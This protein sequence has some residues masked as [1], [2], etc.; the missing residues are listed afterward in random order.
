MKRGYTHVKMFKEEILKMR[1]SGCTHREISEHLD[2]K[3]KYVIKKF[4][5]REKQNQE[6]L[7]AGIEPKTRGRPRKD[8]QPPQQNP[9]T[10]LKRLRMENELLRDFL[11]LAGRR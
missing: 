2:F 3:D 6:K 10:E 4:L 9:E 11:R 5:K 1:K 7:K 8:R